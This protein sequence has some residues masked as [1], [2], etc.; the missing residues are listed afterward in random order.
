MAKY[1]KLLAFLTVVT[2]LNKAYNKSFERD[3]P[4]RRPT[5]QTLCPKKSKPPSNFMNTI[6]KFICSICLC[7]SQA[8]YANEP[9]DS[10]KLME[11]ADSFSACSG[12]YGAFADQFEKEG[13]SSEI[14]ENFRGNMRGAKMAA[15]AIIKDARNE[16]KNLQEY[17][18]YIDSI[19]YPHK[20]KTA[21]GFLNPSISLEDLI[22]EDLAVCMQL[23]PLQAKIINELRRQHHLE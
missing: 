1:Q 22:A 11:I 2:L 17:Y 4:L 15:A 9:K 18:P 16:N 7:I 13:M 3:Y 23:N 8:L 21:L 6:T 19:A 12:K 20:Q 5:T 14:I 10:E